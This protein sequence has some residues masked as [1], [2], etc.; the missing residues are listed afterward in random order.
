MLRLTEVKVAFVGVF[1]FNNRK[2]TKA[3]SFKEMVLRSE[4]CGWL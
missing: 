2:V 1:C 3:F 4:K